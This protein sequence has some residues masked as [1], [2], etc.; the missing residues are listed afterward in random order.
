[1]LRKKTFDSM[2]IEGFRV[3]T[4]INFGF[5]YYA[6]HFTVERKKATQKMN[7]LFCFLSV[8]FVFYSKR[9][10]SLTKAKFVAHHRQRFLCHFMLREKEAK[11]VRNFF[12]RQSFAGLV[13]GS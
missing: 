13:T 5:G 3:Q 6:K 8:R 9:L 12:T 4:K 2:K 10:K 11:R 1:M 7:R